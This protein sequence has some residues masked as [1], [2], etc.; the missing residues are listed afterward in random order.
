[1]AKFRDVIV[2]L[3]VCAIILIGFWSIYAALYLILPS[4]ILLFTS[5]ILLDRKQ[6]KQYNFS[7]MDWCI[8]LVVFTEFLCYLLSSYKPN[9]ISTALNVL[10]LSLLY[11]FIRYAFNKS[12]M[13]NLITIFVVLYGTLLVLFTLMSFL[14]FQFN[15]SYEGFSNILEFRNM[16]MPLGFYSNS[17]VTVLIILLPFQIS[18]YIDNHKMWIRIVSGVSFIMT[19][20][21]IM[22]SFSRGGY[23]ALAIFALLTLVYFVFCKTVSL[24]KLVIYGLGIGGLVL[25][26]ILPYNDSV[27]STIKMGNTTSHQRSFEGRTKVWENSLEL[28]KANPLVGTGANNFTLSYNVNIKNEESGFVGRIANTYLQILIEKGIIGLI[29]YGVLIIVF[30]L[31][32]YRTFNQKISKQT[33]SIIFSA[34]IISILIRELSFNSMFEIDGLM[35]LFFIIIL[36]NTHNA[37][38]HCEM[39]QFS[40][41]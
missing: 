22:L 29:A 40:K 20:Y 23:I 34:A 15:V 4:I 13:L 35:L 38:I 3:I 37:K 18:T 28:I 24:K 2:L 16:Y 9:S 39:P 12:Y 30:F 41:A 19:I 32:S 26:L 21:A 27:L 1:M 17:W 25:L 10:G 14:F 36:N 31:N 6:L 5:D 11:F 8:L 7:L 33:H